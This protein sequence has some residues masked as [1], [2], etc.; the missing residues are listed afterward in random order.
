MVMNDVGSDVELVQSFVNTVNLEEGP[1][2]LASPRDLRSWLAGAG[3][4]LPGRTPLNRDDLHRVIAVREALRDLVGVNMGVALPADAYAVLQDAAKR[5]DV[6][7]RFRPDG[8]TVTESA[9]TGVD[10]AV[11]RI[12]AA[13]HRAMDRG[14][15]SQLK[16]CGRDCCRWAFL[17]TSKNKSKR[18]CSMET[19]GNREK[20]EAFRHRH[21]QI[22]ETPGS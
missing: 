10:G 5:A 8:S 4:P 7:V 14:T 9:A 12:L 2:A 6:S 18:W 15:W 1:D 21:R 20:G 17:D 19:C 16:L 3:L 22:A 11:G 13:A